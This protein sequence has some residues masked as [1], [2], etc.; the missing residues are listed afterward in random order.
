MK[1][2]FATT[3]LTLTLAPAAFA[4]DAL[5]HVNGKTIT[6]KQLEE[7]MKT[8]P[9]A[10]LGGREQEVRQALLERLIE[11][12]LILQQADKMKIETLPEYKQ[13]MEQLTKNLKYSM[14][15]K[16]ALDSGLTDKAIKSYYE[17]N[18]AKFAYPAIHAAHI[19]LPSKE[20]AEKLRKD[21]SKD[22]D[23]TAAAKEHS[24]GPSGPNGGDL[25]WFGKGT[26]VPAFEEAAF[27]L[28]AGEISAPVQTQFGWHLIKVIEKDDKR[29]PSLSEV[30]SNIRD[31][32]GRELL[33]SYLEGLR[34]DA[35]IKQVEN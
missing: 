14:V 8:V 29:T 26:M 25:G 1:R 17:K 12:Q 31:E 15:L 4:D 9:A 7:Q 13:Q 28:K 27:N 2:F 16:K 33:T 23:F 6:Q 24:T 22:G 5:V 34:K 3:L 19:L 11:E 10:L 32:L 35:D 30:E 18:K 20:A 21:L